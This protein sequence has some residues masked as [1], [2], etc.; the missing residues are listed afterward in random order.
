MNYVICLE[1]LSILRPPPFNSFQWLTCCVKTCVTYCISGIG[2]VHVIFTSDFM[3]YVDLQIMMSIL[4]HILSPPFGVGDK[5]HGLGLSEVTLRESI[6]LLI[7]VL[8]MK[9]NVIGNGSWSPFYYYYYYQLQV[10]VL[11]WL[12]SQ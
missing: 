7:W 10:G 11:T 8:I 5:D 2:L 12:I 1:F 6:L 9:P 3:I 4:V